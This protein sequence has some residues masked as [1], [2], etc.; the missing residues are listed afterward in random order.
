MI[1]SDEIELFRGG[2]FKFKF[3]VVVELVGIGIKILSK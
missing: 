1:I 2:K 3:E